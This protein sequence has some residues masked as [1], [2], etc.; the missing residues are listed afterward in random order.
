MIL[1]VLKPYFISNHH[2]NI[3]SWAFRMSGQH[4]MSIIEQLICTS[5]QK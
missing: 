5:E 3:N 4:Y 2:A 1:I